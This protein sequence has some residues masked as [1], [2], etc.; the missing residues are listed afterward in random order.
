MTHHHDTP[1]PDKY[2]RVRNPPPAPPATPS[3]AVRE[4]A[5]TTPMHAPMGVPLARNEGI[6]WHGLTPDELAELRTDA[7][8]HGAD[9]LEFLGYTLIA[10]DIANTVTG[11]LAGPDVGLA[12]APLVGL[13]TTLRLN[14]ARA[15]AQNAA[16]AAKLSRQFG[17]QEGVGAP[18][19]GGGKAIA[20]AGTRV[21]LRDAGRLVSEYG[22]K[23]GDWAKVT[24]T[25]PGHL[26]THAYRNVVTGEVVELKSIVP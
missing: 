9:A 12:G 21:P 17:S 11:V 4:V 7:S 3:P 2:R 10:L 5:S 24:S 19:S 20:G 18:L 22:G 15:G 6:A 23:V 13:A 26:Q 1:M 14:A 8:I 16:N 25:A